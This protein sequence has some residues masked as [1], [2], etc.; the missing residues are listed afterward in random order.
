MGTGVLPQHRARFGVKLELQ[1]PFKHIR[2]GRPVPARPPAA[3]V[4]T[5]PVLLTSWVN[6][7]PHLRRPNEPHV[8]PLGV[9][10]ATGDTH[11]LWHMLWPWAT[12]WLRLTRRCSGAHA[13]TL[14]HSLPATTSS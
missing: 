8:C 7:D 1:R 9:V 12:L 10:F 13:Q 5:T 6:L 14:G 11:A 4:G 3:Q 2:V